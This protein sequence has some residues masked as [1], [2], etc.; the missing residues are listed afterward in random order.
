MGKQGKGDDTHTYVMTWHTKCV[1]PAQISTYV[2]TKTKRN[3]VSFVFRVNAFVLRSV[4]QDT[5]N[6]GKG[7]H[8][9]WHS[10]RARRH[11]LDDTSF[12]QCFMFK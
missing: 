2:I 10:C 9:I 4:L 6:G 5:L 7:M 1:T 12:T 3:T 8:L 11:A